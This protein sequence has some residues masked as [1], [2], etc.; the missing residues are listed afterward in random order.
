MRPAPLALS[1]LLVPAFALATGCAPR[2]PIAPPPPPP[3]PAAPVSIWGDGDS[4]GVAKQL[5]EAAT[6]DPWTS[7]FRD[8]NGRSAKI[9]VATIEDRSGKMV[10]V[11]DFSA[12]ITSAIAE[13]GGDKLTTGES[14]SADYLVRGIIAGSTGSDANGSPATFFAI[15]LSFVDATSGDSQWHFA[16]E[17]PIADR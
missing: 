3:P 4:Q 7:Q 11:D 1:L 17:R 2:E 10:P 8:R 9:A 5:V 15:D 12:A 13:L 14:G 16:V 6:R